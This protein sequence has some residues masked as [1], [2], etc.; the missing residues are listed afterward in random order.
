[1]EPRHSVD[2]QVI[3]GF[4]INAPNRHIRKK[5]KICGHL[6]VDTRCM[7]VVNG[8]Q[9]IIPFLNKRFTLT[10]NPFVVAQFIALLH[11]DTL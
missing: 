11:A 6:S 2:V 1:M 5:L 4:T 10:K 8:V 9:M 7:H 3:M